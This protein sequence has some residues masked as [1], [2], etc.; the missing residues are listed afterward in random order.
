M[1]SYASL[2]NGNGTTEITEDWDLGEDIATFLKV[3]KIV[4]RKG[5][6]TID[7]ANST[8]HGIVRFDVQVFK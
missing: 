8:S 5:V 3:N 2:N 7:F 4:I 1:I 6:Y